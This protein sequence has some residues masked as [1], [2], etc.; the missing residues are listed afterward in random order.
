MCRLQRPDIALYSQINRQNVCF[1]AVRLPYSAPSKRNEVNIEGCYIFPCLGPQCEKNFVH[2]QFSVFDK[3]LNFVYYCNLMLRV[4][5][6]TRNCN[7][8][9]VRM[10]EWT[11]SDNGHSL[12]VPRCHLNLYML[13]T[14]AL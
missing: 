5:T 8:V 1:H 4:C 9:F 7:P 6:A 3:L 13:A 11:E 10:M 14:L 2:V 12:V